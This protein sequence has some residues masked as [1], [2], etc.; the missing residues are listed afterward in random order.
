MAT[1]R[2]SPI[3]QKIRQLEYEL[4]GRCRRLC[5]IQKALY[6]LNVLLKKAGRKHK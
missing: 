3:S 1:R 4:S 5:R 2:C 6:E